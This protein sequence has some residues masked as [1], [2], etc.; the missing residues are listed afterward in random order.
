[1][2]GPVEDLAYAAPKGLRNK[3]LSQ[4][5]DGLAFENMTKGLPLM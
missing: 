4:D 2:D 5:T 3:P 1:M